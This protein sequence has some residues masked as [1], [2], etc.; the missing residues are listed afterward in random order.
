MYRDGN[1]TKNT[2]S[3]NHDDLLNVAKV[4]ERAE[5]WIAAKTA[6]HRTRAAA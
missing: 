2:N 3:F 6:E 4:S 1:E 5:A